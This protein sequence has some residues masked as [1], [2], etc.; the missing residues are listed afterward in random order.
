MTLQSRKPLMILC[1][2]FLIVLMSFGL[3]EE[4]ATE[5]VAFVKASRLNGRAYPR[6]TASIEAVFDR[7][8]PLKTT[9]K[10]SRDHRWIEVEGGETGTVWVKI[11]YI[12]ERRGTILVKNT[13]HKKV[14]VR[15]H[16]IDGRVI[17]YVRKGESVDISQ[18]VLG[19]GKCAKGWVDLNYLT[20]VR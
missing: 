15:K 1:L 7:D 20:E 9:G 19:W 17:A 14:K 5:T 8:D 12:S 10:W 16:P 3:A 2:V 13:E 4:T 18:I 11:S 6:K